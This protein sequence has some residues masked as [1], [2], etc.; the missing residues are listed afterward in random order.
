LVKPD[1]DALKERLEE[2]D[3]FFNKGQLLHKNIG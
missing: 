1:T 2:V 3:G